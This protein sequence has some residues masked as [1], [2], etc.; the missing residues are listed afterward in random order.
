MTQAQARPLQPLATGKVCGGEAQ[1]RG[2]KRTRPRS[3]RYRSPRPGRE[4]TSAG[5]IS[6]S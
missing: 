5:S 3:D 4:T 6:W 2:P 1:A